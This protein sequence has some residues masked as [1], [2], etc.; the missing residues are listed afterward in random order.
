MSVLQ[1]YGFPSPKCILRNYLKPL[2]PQTLLQPEPFWGAQ[3]V[4]GHSNVHRIQV[5]SLLMLKLPSWASLNASWT[6]NSDPA[7]YQTQL[8][9]DVIVWRKD[10]WSEIR[11]CCTEI[12]RPHIFCISNCNCKSGVFPRCCFIQISTRLTTCKLVKSIWLFMTHFG[13]WRF[14]GKKW[15]PRIP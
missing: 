3:F 8:G 6:P 15:L 7:W 2:I 4:G 12:I 5:L 11:V 13:G 9:N 10:E 14:F 1:S